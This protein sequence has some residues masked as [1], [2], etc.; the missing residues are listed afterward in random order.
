MDIRLKSMELK[1]F[2]GIRSY[3]VDFNPHTT[4]INGDNG[5]G[6]T[7][8]F[9]AFTWLLFNKDSN[10]KADFQIKTIENKK[11]MSGVEH[12]VKAILVV[13]GKET[14]LEKVY[15]EKWTKQ[16]GAP[17]K[18]LTGHE[19]EYWVNEVP[20]KQKDY[21]KY[22]AE[23]V[24]QKIFA[25]V[26]NP[27][28]FNNV[29]SWQERRN[30][31][32]EVSGGITDEDVI[33]SN[34]E[35]QE[36]PDILKGASVDDHKTKTAASKRK[37]NDSLKEIPARIDELQN[38]LVDTAKYDIDQIR[39]DIKKL[40]EKIENKKAG[41]DTSDLRKKRSELENEIDKIVSQ[42]TKETREKRSK[43]EDQKDDLVK[44]LRSTKSEAEH[45]NNKIT[46]LQNYI[47]AKL[48][49]IQYHGSC[50][51]KL[52]EEGPQGE[53]CRT[54]GQDIPEDKIKLAHANKL[55]EIQDNGKAAREQYDKLKT[56]IAEHEEQL[57]QFQQDNADLADKIEILDRQILEIMDPDVDKFNDVVKRKEEIESIC[58]LIAKASSNTDVSELQT[59]LANLRTQESEY[60]ASIKTRE[61]IKELAGEEKELAAEYE[62]LE[63][64]L[65]ILETFI[66]AKVDLM[67][68]KIN[69]KFKLA[70]F[71][72]FENQV[73]G[74]IKEICVTTDMSG[75][76]CG[77]GLNRGAEMNIGL[78]I[79]NALSEHYR[80]YAQVWIDN[81][82]A[83]TK[84]IEI[85]SQLIRL[86][87][88]E[89]AKELEVKSYEYEYSRS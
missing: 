9:D 67:E 10:N 74:G 87:V 46:E 17:Q 42:A 52:V 60:I 3:K 15:Q 62:E 82:E 56:Q 1:N 25:L 8:L 14:I 28:Y 88:D 69:S 5:T 24:D 84:P 58:S 16:K 23:M 13:D 63:R 2:K 33:K 38:S 64:Q 19:T 86:V 48:K 37:L 73:N 35:L 4:A 47:G 75:V 32:M 12:A 78:D 40:D 50:Y 57:K 6:K 7:T 83:V 39:A 53:T 70:R 18:T 76:K 21:D 26:S 66:K 27:A 44:K 61:R 11:E 89:D 36:L 71:K 34:K 72:L 45:H 79:V 85:G 80:V 43:L 31:L 81:A 68:G 20:V 30:I 29:L 22:I 65:L 51:K 59:E 55:K 54:C 77:Y 49:D 41:A